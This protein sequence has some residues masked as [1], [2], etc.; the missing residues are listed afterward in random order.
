MYELA[1]MHI[2]YV[3]A[4][5][6]QYSKARCYEVGK[7]GMMDDTTGIS[8]LCSHQGIIQHLFELP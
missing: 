1:C 3:C 5:Y 2:I 4:T 8:L 6:P 7:R